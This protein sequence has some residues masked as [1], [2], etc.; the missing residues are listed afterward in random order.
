MKA[1]LKKLNGKDLKPTEILR[2]P[3]KTIMGNP[4]QV[5]LSVAGKSLA[6][7]S[8]IMYILRGSADHVVER[9]FWFPDY[10]SKSQMSTYNVYLRI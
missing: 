1:C 8:S 4:A 3:P 6:A 2:D 5:S 10:S 9:I 7:L